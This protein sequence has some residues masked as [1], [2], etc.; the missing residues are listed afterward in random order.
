MLVVVSCSQASVQETSSSLRVSDVL[1][2][3]S[4]ESQEIEIIKSEI[5]KR[6]PV[7]TF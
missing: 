5:K 6:K 2:G 3:G 7:K 1:V 4:V